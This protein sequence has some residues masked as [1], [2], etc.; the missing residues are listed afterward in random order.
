[1]VSKEERISKIKKTVGGGK[2]IIVSNREPYEHKKSHKDIICK[3][4]TGGVVS[5]LDR[6]MQECGGTWVCWGS[7]SADFMVS[8]SDGKVKV[9]PKKQSY[10]LKRLKLSDAERKGYYFGFSN[11]ILWPLSHLKVSTS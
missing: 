1:M 4:P 9:P 7:G 3:M 11:Q 5:S 2:L 10:T 8:G 6:V